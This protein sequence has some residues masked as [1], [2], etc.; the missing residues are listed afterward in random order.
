MSYCYN[1]GKELGEQSPNFCSHCGAN[2]LRYEP[3]Q[4]SKPVL[5]GNPPVVTVLCILTILGSSFGIIRG[6]LYEAVAGV[7]H[8]DDYVYGYTFAFLNL[9]T[10]I[11]AIMM[12][13]QK[14]LG[15]YL[16]IIF[17]VLYIVM[18]IFRTMDYWEPYNNYG[19]SVNSFSFLISTIFIVPSVIFLLLYIMLTAKYF[20]NKRN[21]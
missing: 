12:L 6:M 1:C 2:Q 3:V 21:Q 11:A 8:N 7:T 17:Q 15:F 20:V 16:Y 4:P 9:G 10:L 18:V 13:A 14:S 5:K 19:S